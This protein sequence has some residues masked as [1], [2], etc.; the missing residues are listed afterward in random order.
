LASPQVGGKLRLVAACEIKNEDWI[1]ERWLQRTGEFA[2]G[3]I[4]VDDGSTDRTWAL[5]LALVRRIRPAAASVLTGGWDRDSFRG[6]ELGGARGW[7]LS[8]S[9]ALGARW[10]ATAEPSA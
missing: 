9:G 5:L 4:V 10:R 6:T 3:I 2:D 8:V 1:I 7:V